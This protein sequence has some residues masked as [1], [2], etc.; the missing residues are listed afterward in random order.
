M[1]VTVTTIKVKSML[2]MKIVKESIARYQAV[3]PT[4]P[5]A[6][7]DKL[8]STL[9]LSA[10]EIAVY[11]PRNSLAVAE[12]KIDLELSMFIYNSLMYWDHVGL[13]ERLV[14]TQLFVVLMRNA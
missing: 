14:L 1:L 9:D 3:I 10:Q 12:G 2:S 7:M 6:V 4:K 5:K 13:A 11:A 8:Y